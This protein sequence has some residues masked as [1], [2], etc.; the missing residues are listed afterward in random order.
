MEFVGKKA[1][2]KIV[3]AEVALVI[4]T[5][6]RG[7]QNNGGTGA[8]QPSES[9]DSSFTHNFQGGGGGGLF[10]SLSSADARP[11]VANIDFQYLS[12]RY[13]VSN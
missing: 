10:N 13:R 8:H 12:F 3:A 5:W 6:I 4:A 7:T 2:I 11:S 9:S 1:S